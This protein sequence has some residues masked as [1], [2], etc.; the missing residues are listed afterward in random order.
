MQLVGTAVFAAVVAYLA[1]LIGEPS[2][3]VRILLGIFLALVP[4]L[5]WLAYFYAQD[6]LQPEP[7]TRVAL[8]FATG[9]VLTDVLAR[10]VIYDW[11]HVLDWAPY[12][13]LT[14]LGASI[15]VQA[16]MYQL[17][18][19]IAI[20][21]VYSS[22]EMD[23]RMD[24]MVYG[25]VAGLGIA[26][27]LNLRYI[28]DSQGVELA[29]GVVRTVTTAL[30]MASFSSLL[31]WFMAEAKFA[32]RPIWWVPVGFAITVVL[33][34]VFSW[35]IGEVSVAGLSIEPWRSLA[36]GLVI[37]LGTFLI[38]AVLMRRAEE[39]LLRGAAN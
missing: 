22:S 35:L 14:S 32:H 10:R 23:E 12:N 39:S 21:M 36:F 5:L 6:R 9:F 11:F 20:R 15:L 4:S 28:I 26:T 24:G 8:V 31:G 25:A 7:K 27:M 19:Y 30:A 29:P 3:G 13:T 37:A 16:L 18:A 33:S 34:G 17:A 38:Q 2:F 1:T